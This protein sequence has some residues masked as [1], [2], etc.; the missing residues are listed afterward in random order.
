MRLIIYVIIILLIF[1]IY[2]YYPTAIKESLTEL[3][4]SQ[5]VGTIENL[6]NFLE[7]LYTVTYTNENNINSSTNAKNT[8]CYKIKILGTYIQPV[9]STLDTTSMEI[10]FNIYG[11]PKQS[12]GDDSGKPPVPGIITSTQDYIMLLQLYIAGCNLNVFATSPDYALWKEDMNSEQATPASKSNTTTSPAPQKKVTDK[13]EKKDA[14]DKPAIEYAMSLYNIIKRSLRHFHNQVSNT[15]TVTPGDISDTMSY[16]EGMSDYYSPYIKDACYDPP[17]NNVNICNGSPKPQDFFFKYRTTSYVDYTPGTHTLTPP[18]NES[19]FRVLLIGG[20]G[21]GGGSATGKK[22]NNGRHQRGGGGGG[23]GGG[24]MSYSEL[25][26]YKNNYQITVGQGGSKGEKGDTRIR[27]GKPGRNGNASF[28]YDTSNKQTLSIANGGIGG[29]GGFLARGNSRQKG[30]SSV[31]TQGKGG[32]GGTGNIRNG[33]E[34]KGGG[35]RTFTGGDPG[36]S[37]TWSSDLEPTIAVRNGGKGGE[38]W[39]STAN[40]Y[41]M[42]GTHGSSGT[43]GLVRVYWIP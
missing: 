1:L 12:L 17:P 32:A 21:G 29:G 15:K 24:G 2:L 9:L 40:K 33:N 28:L 38:S 10:L 16:S 22:N 30:F 27:E 25:Y 4:E 35:D 31:G 20:G 5:D 3:S 7:Q 19:K 11:S 37:N 36:T 41:Y 26:Q 43:G 23:G 34:G 18:N 42:E 13:C 8:V 6:R 14:A 39:I